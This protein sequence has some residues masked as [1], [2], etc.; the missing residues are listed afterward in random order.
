MLARGIVK[1]ADILKVGHHGSVTSSSLPFL[2]AV[3]PKIAVISAGRNNRYGHP[4]QTILDRLKTLN[5]P[6]LRVDQDGSIRCSL[7]NSGHR[8]QADP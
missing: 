3:T 4:H 6:V 1:H 2:E 5:I 8:C 7:T